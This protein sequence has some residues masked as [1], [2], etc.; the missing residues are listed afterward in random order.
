[1]ILSWSYLNSDQ[2]Q[3]TELKEAGLCGFA[4]AESSVTYEWML[5]GVF[6]SP[7]P[8]NVMVD[9]EVCADVSWR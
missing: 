1:M 2:K 6:A 7:V 3:E 5:Q 4:G 9:R 8:Q